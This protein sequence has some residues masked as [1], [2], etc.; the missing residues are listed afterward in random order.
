[1]SHVMSVRVPAMAWCEDAS[2]NRI[3]FSESRRVIGPSV[4]WP[5]P[6]VLHDR[7][8]S[9]TPSI[10]G[11]G[12]DAVMA[13]RGSGDDKRVW[14]SLQDQPVPN[15]QPGHS[16]YTWGGQAPA[17][18]FETPTFPTVARY[19]SRTFLFFKGTAQF[20]NRLRW[21]E[22]RD[23]Q[24]VHPLTGST[25]PAAAEFDFVPGDG[26]GVAAHR[27]DGR[28]YMA[29]RGPDDQ[30]RIRWRSY[31]GGGWTN[32]EYTEL[33]TSHVPALAS[34]G[35]DLFMAWRNAHDDHISWARFTGTSWGAPQTLGDR[36]TDNAPALG[37]ADTGKLVMVWVG[38]G[39]DPAL[40]WSEYSGGQWGPQQAFSDRSM[41][42]RLRVSLA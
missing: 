39:G 37:V 8:S 38:T 36:R 40:W 6:R 26:V 41:K 18:H 2:D 20:Q 12:Q 28:L 34:D 32:Y 5:E 4:R 14:F 22:L 35:V 3:R 42:P 25:E 29:F 27:P 21:S 10:A 9:D 24:W 17:R 16:R 1:M 7:R 30:S 31:D 15:P 11:V 19:G 13:W 33:R 23:R